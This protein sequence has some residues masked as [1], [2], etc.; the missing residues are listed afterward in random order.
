VLAQDPKPKRHITP[1]QEPSKAQAQAKDPNTSPTG[2][3]DEATKKANCKSLSMADVH[4]ATN[5]IMQTKNPGALVTLATE[6]Q[7]LHERNQCEHKKRLQYEWAG[8]AITYSGHIL[9]FTTG[10][11]ITCGYFQRTRMTFW[12]V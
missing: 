3:V 12:I 6:K 1:A 5:T 4:A 8:E 11:A 7:S 10:D 9:E 2:K